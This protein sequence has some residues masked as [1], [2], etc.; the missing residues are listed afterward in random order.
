MQDHWTTYGRNFYQ[1]RDYEEVPVEDAA[2]VFNAL[3][4]HIPVWNQKS[5]GY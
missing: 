1:K 5:E 3:E 4:E 2:K